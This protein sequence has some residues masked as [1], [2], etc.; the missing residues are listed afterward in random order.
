MSC[1]DRAHGA[2]DPSNDLAIRRG[3]S[4]VIAELQPLW[5]SLH[6][7]HAAIAPHLLE[8]GPVRPPSHSWAVRRR[9]Y[10]EWL[11]EPDSFAL[12]AKDDSKAVGYAVVHMRGPEETWATDDRIAELETLTVLPDYRG[13]GI[14]T[15]LVE[16]VNRELRRLGIRHL[17]V[18]VI[19][20]NKDA[21][22]FY[23]RL[24]LLPFL[25]S[26]IANVP[27]PGRWH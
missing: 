4:E 9:L 22:R 13:R 25:T 16:A 1:M 6:H 5:E 21:L 14:G 8:L 2:G 17:G 24:G 19:A 26:Y 27:P 23:E 3:G 7:H 15:T 11:A 18:S 12:V 20:S 10:E